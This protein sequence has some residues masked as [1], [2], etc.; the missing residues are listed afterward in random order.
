M[1]QILLISSFMKW[2]HISKK[3]ISFFLK[4]GDFLFMIAEME[5]IWYTYDRSKRNVYIKESLQN[6]TRN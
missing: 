4:R 2:I 5:S 3:S 1:Y 6:E